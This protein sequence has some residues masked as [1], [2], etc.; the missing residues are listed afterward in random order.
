MTLH[1]IRI[2]AGGTSLQSFA[3]WQARHYQLRDGKKVAIIRTYSTP[4][5]T[6]EILD[7]GGSMYR[8]LKGS[9]RFRQKIIGFEHVQNDPENK[10]CRIILDPHIIRTEIMPKRAFQG[11]RYLKPADAP[12]DIG[13]YI[14][15]E[16]ESSMEFEAELKALGVL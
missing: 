7:G 14:E 5:R 9:I 1:M 10:S 15:G 4:R 12:A 11:W 13:P 8:V 2:V 6:Q 16:D 3:D